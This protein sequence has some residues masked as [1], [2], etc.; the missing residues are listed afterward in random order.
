MGTLGG[1][2]EF[3]MAQKLRITTPKTAKAAPQKARNI[4]FS[5]CKNQTSGSA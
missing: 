2:T 3:R 1:K 4:G 5:H